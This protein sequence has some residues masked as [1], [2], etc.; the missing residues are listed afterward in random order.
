[1]S[2]GPIA[3]PVAV[4]SP[5]ATVAAAPDEAPDPVLLWVTADDGASVAVHRSANP[6][7]PPVVLVH[8]VSSNSRFWDLA[9]GRSLAGYLWARGFDVWNVDL[10]GHGVAERSEDGSRLAA[11][12]TIDDYGRHDVP[13]VFAAV[14]AETGATPA[15]VGH[16][17]GGMV[18]AVALATGGVDPPAAVVVGSPLDFRDPDLLVGLGLGGLQR[19]ARIVP[20]PVGAKVLAI[21]RRSTLLELDALLFVPENLAR[22][23][24]VSVLRTAVSPLW[25]GEIGQLAACRGDGEFRGVDGGDPYRAQLAQ[26]DVPMLFLAGREDRI[27]SPDRVWTYFEAVG[28]ALPAVDKAFVVASVANGMH[29]D[30]G[31]LDLGVGDHAAED[32]F[33][34]IAGWLEAHP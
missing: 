13:A 10:R 26:V 8:G 24:E 32:V 9:P 18:L 15:Y 5:V 11:S 16:S 22:E 14:E 2:P 28:S 7:K 19:V 12:P 21:T 17:M 3:S 4:S 6:G 30:Y 20:T 31:H 25:S 33:P 29:A 1:M 27:V 34:L 23:A